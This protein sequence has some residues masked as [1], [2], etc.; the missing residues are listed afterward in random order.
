MV[1]P[2]ETESKET[3][4][5]AVEVLRK[6]YE[7]AETDAEQLHQAPVTTPVTR[8]DEVGAKKTSISAIR[9]AGLISYSLKRGKNYD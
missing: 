5:E 4:D 9:M 2:T 3:L 1:E 8:M 6:L 7:I